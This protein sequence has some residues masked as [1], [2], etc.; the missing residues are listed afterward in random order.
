MATVT[1]SSVI[2]A[3]VEAVW[4]RIRDFNGLPNWHPRM[5]T[6]HI[7][8]G[9][10]ADQIGCVRNFQLV[11]GPTLREQ[12]VGMSERD[13]SVTYSI[14]ETPQPL[15]NH[16]AMLKLSAVTDGNRT[17]AAYE[18]AGDLG[19]AIPLYE[20]A[21][22]DSVRVLGQDHPQTKIVRGNLAIARQQ[23]QQRSPRHPYRLRRAFGWPRRTRR[24]CS[25]RSGLIPR[26]RA[27]SVVNR[28][29]T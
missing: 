16:I 22:A 2:D 19:R 17:S 24:L 8:G 3:P 4:A 11:T 6:S 15:T 12:L 1:I 21:L 13:H 7:E 28:L 9:L 29:T 18:D 26:E 25:R 23:P 10:A 5:K 20:Q 27:R 14:L